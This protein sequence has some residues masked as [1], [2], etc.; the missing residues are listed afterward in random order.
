MTL[1]QTVDVTDAGTKYYEGYALGLVGRTGTL[2]EHTEKIRTIEEALRAGGLHNTATFR[3][4]DTSG[5]LW[6]FGFR[7]TGRELVINWVIAIAEGGDCLHVYYPPRS[8]IVKA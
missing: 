1:R 5:C 4:I 2:L 3:Q 8:I 7:C 6:S